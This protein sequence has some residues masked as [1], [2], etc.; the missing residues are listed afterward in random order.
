[1][2]YLRAGLFAEGRSDYDFLLRLLD[3]LLEAI[4]ARL[5][6]G[7]Y[8]VGE[9]IGIDAPEQLRKGKRADRI[10]A[11]VFEFT[12]MFELLVI[13]ADGDADPKAARSLRI[14]P[15][16][17]AVHALN[18]E[19]PPALVACVP[20]RETEAWM[21]TDG[22][23]FRELLGDKVAPALPTNP[24][25]G[26]PKVTLQQVLKD[27]GGRRLPGSIHAFF[28]ERVDLTTLRRL[29]AFQT[30]EA[31]LTAAVREVARSQGHRDD[32]QST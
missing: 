26:D 16:V 13:H 4:A 30:F 19:H 15:G 9:A 24:E 21:L 25:I 2:I 31:G 6:P 1:M 23:V 22:R 28:G 10:A 27:C 3:R 11:A 8:E 20:V 29:P 32:S 14:E 7:A 17:A 12:G 5:Y 18:L